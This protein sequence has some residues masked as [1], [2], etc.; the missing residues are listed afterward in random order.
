MEG[1]NHSLE[2]AGHATLD[3]AW[4]SDGSKVVEIHMTDVNS[5]PVPMCLKF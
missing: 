3:A 4:D 5:I 2:P 1:Q